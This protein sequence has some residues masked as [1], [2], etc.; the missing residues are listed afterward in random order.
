MIDRLTD[1]TITERDVLN[2]MKRRDTVL[3]VI[4]W[5]LYAYLWMPGI[6]LLAW[7]V[8]FDF[9]Y[10]TVENAG[11]VEELLSLL[12]SFGILLVS[13]ICIVIGWS[14]SQYWRFH[15]KNRRTATPPPNAEAEQA[16]WNISAAQFDQV[17]N[18][19]NII[20]GIDEN[21]VMT[22]VRNVPP[23]T[24][25]PPEHSPTGRHRR[26]DRATIHQARSATTASR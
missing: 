16:L 10:T 8:G 12:A 4:L 20:L 3:T 18:G 21:L 19:K 5:M 22:S 26:A 11:G 25:T 1:T 23:P 14:L 24:E 7:Y 2:T 9:A 17:R 15:N 13:I 6:S